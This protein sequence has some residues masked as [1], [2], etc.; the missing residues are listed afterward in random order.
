M[1]EEGAQRH[2]FTLWSIQSELNRTTRDLKVLAKAEGSETTIASLGALL[3][4]YGGSAKKVYQELSET[5][6][7]LESGFLKDISNA[8]KGLH[9]CDHCAQPIVGVDHAVHCTGRFRECDW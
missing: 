8:P 6:H 4:A 3:D 7:K 2:A 5:N 9:T 1:K